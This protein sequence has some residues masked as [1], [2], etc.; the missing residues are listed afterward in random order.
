MKQINEISADEL[1]AQVPTLSSWDAAIHWIQKGQQAIGKHSQE[2]LLTLPFASFTLPAMNPDLLFGLYPSKQ[3]QQF[4][5]ATYLADLLSYTEPVDQVDF[6]RLLFVM[7]AFPQGFKTWWVQLP[8]QDWWPVGY[9]GWYPMLETMFTQ[10]EQAPETLKNR[11]VVPTQLERNAYLYLFNYS[12]APLF[13]KSPL[14]Q[15]LMR[16]LAADVHAVQAAGLACITVSDEGMRIAHR[17]GMQRTGY[18]TLD[19]CLEGVYV[20]RR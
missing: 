13:K 16:E 17:F 10:F 20:S 5:L 15:A 4:V 18:L 9:S 6:S 1:L 12:A 3:W 19:G 14:T 2:Q 8:S 11:M 7:H